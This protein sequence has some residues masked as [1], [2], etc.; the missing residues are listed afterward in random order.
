MKQVRCRNDGADAV[1]ACLDLTAF[2][3]PG[4]ITRSEKVEGERLF[5]F[6][7]QYQSHNFIE[8]A[9][10]CDCA[11]VVVTFVVQNKEL[12]PLTSEDPCQ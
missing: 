10:K 12:F 5:F 7:S 2:A 3:E 6:N 4:G 9:S 11:A 8:S 1:W